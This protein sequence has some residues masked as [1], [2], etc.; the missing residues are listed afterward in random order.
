[1]FKDEFLKQRAD[2]MANAKTELTAGNT[3]KANE[4]MA[5]VKKLD[6]D[7]EAGAK[8]QADLNALKD[9]QPMAPNPIITDSADGKLKPIA[10]VQTTDTENEESKEDPRYQH[11]WA[12]F[13]MGKTLDATE[14]KVL[15]S[16]NRVENAEFSHQTTNTPTLIPQTVVAGI[17]KLAEEEYPLFADA[18][19]FNVK[20]KLII[21]KHDGIVAGDAQWVDEDAVADD[22]ENKFGQLILDG[23]ELN[24]VAT[25]SWKMKAMSEADFI[26]FLTKELADRV[27]VALGVATSHGTGV[28]QPKGIITLLNEEES[29]PQVK[30]YTDQVGYKDLTGAM[31]LIHSTLANGTAVYANN[32]TIWNQLA[33]VVDGNGRPMFVADTNNGGVGNIFGRTVKADAGLKDGEILIGN[34]S[35]TVD[36]NTNESMSVA[37]ED[38]VKPRET[39]YGAYAI[40]DLGL[41]T[42]K[43]FALLSSAPKA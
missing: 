39:D 22:E 36:V 42:T 18:R 20:G 40:V 27:G 23:Y 2:L 15:D 12:K 14:A 41:L 13:A 25:V 31:G 28:K 11:A 21:N 5:K 43:G 32:A 38:H 24:K 26:T 9:N 19:K 4:I 34:V 1:M 6:A 10:T 7:A 16:V 17:W 30:T 29:T 3:D 33:N 35:E 37:M 8:A